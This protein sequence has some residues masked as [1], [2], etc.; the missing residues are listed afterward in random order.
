MAIREIRKEG[1]PCLTKVCRKVEKFD[2]RLHILLDDMKETLTLSQ[3]VGLAAP[4]VGILKRVFVIDTPDRGMV[5]F[6]NPVIVT[7]EGSYIDAEGCLSLPGKVGSVERPMKTTVKAFDRDG[8]EFEYTGEELYS[9]CI[10]HENDH[11]DGILYASKVIEW[12]DMEDED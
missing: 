2:E 5:E 6:V 10:C 1:D 9:K 11:L 8:N 4:Q 3:G 12:L 7:T